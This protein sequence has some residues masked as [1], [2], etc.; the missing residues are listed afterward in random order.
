MP[1]SKSNETRHSASRF[2][3]AVILLAGLI[4][5]QAVLYG[6]SL[7]GRKILL[8]LDLLALRGA[9]LPK[10]EQYAKVEPFD[11]TL[12]DEV[13]LFEFERRFATE[14][15]RAG[16]LPLWNPYIYLST[17]FV[18]WDKYSPFNLVYYLFPVP[19]TLAWIQ[20]LKS[21]VAGVG[22]YV[23]FRRVVGVGFWPATI[24]GWCY[25]LS[26]FFLLWQ[27]YPH[28]S[29]TAWLPWM[30]LSVDSVLRRPLGW[31]GPAL[32]GL[33]SLVLITRIDVGAQ[34][35]LASGL[36]ALWC[37]GRE[38][39]RQPG[40]RRAL[41]G[42]VAI[43]AAWTIGFLLAAP[44][45]LPLA[46]YTRSGDRMLRREAG[47]EER[48][49]GD[50][51]E[52]PRLL[53]PT[54]YG[55]M[56]RGAWLLPG[57]NLLESPAGA[58]TGLLATLVLTPL[59]WCSRRHWAINGFCLFLIVVALSWSL[60]L[61]G[62]VWIFRR[63]GLNL[64]SHNRF[65]FAVSFALLSLAVVGLEVLWQESPPRRWWFAVP[66]AVILVL[67]VWCWMHFAVLPLPEPLATQLETQLRHGSIYQNVSSRAELQEARADYILNQ[68][69]GVVLC[70]LAL[71]GWLLLWF[72]RAGT[73]FR[74]VL[75]TLLLGELLWFGYDRNPQCSLDLYYPRLPVLEQIAE[76]PP[77]R[78]LGIGCL[79]P[80]LTMAY[81]LRDIRGY[82]SIDPRLVIELLDRVRDPRGITA[83]YARLQHYLPVLS[84]DPSGKLRL[85]PVLDMLGVRYLI[86]RGSPPPGIQTRFTASH[87]WAMEN[88]RALPRAFVPQRVEPAPAPD[89]LLELL[90]SPHFDPHSVAYVEETLSSPSGCRGTATIVRETPTEVVV[91]T[92]MET[93]GLVVLTDMWYEG[94]H[95]YLENADVPILRT[96]H[97]LRGV[98]T[99]AG[100]STIVFRYEPSSFTRGIQLLMV[101]TVF[102]GAWLSAGRWRRGRMK[103]Q[104]EG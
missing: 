32:A 82:D 17:P 55:D 14:E 48:P 31:G 42:G 28:S 88:E 8:P 74:P 65:V 84:G 30:F 34:V 102:L 20:L 78:V 93:P 81:H 95:A 60:G 94:W 91:T 35:L 21:I 69:Y 4:V 56:H 23:F 39:V 7:I 76:A 72:R 73:L 75:V 96:N 24:G 46:E 59:A 29:V 87:Y 77:G 37:L 92:E 19:E 6:P 40:L 1:I 11:S 22:A 67:G 27:G 79:P 58:Y 80:N 100:Q 49:P 43:S 53:L 71:V 97:C 89:R 38:Q 2:S 15:F 90:A 50:L 18:V 70:C 101:G 5:P 12:V 25:P 41:A 63:P 66:T 103:G 45:L 44:Y 99:P 16:R 64:L 9:Y 3:G 52:L 98:L 33:T 83:E 62:F 85:P 61:P 47:Q 10:T 54:I 26:G 13:F 51:R 57:G 36:F 104:D 86:F 68:L